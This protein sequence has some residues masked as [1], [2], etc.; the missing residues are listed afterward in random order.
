[1]DTEEAYN[2]IH[3]IAGEDWDRSSSGGV[4][5]SAPGLA[6]APGLGPGLGAG[7]GPGPGLD[8]AQEEKTEEEPLVEPLEEAMV[9]PETEQELALIVKTAKFV[10]AKGDSVE[11]KL[12]EQ[13]KAHF[14]FLDQSHALHRFYRCQV[15]LEGVSFW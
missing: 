12:L 4:S 10:A 6:P 14:G 7:L 2:S 13:K 5:N 15:D 8:P 1:M 3:N 9:E 11:A